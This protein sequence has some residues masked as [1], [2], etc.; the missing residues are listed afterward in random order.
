M[1]SDKRGEDRGNKKE[2]LLLL[3]R[4]RL[5][6]FEDKK[7]GSGRW[8]GVRT[9]VYGFIVQRGGEERGI[10]VQKNNIQYMCVYMCKHVLLANKL[11]VNFFFSS[12]NNL[13]Q[14]IF[15]SGR[16]GQLLST[17]NCFYWATILNQGARTHAA[18]LCHRTHRSKHP[19]NKLFFLL[20]IG[21]LIDRKLTKL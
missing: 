20:F 21:P 11:F 13:T 7:V 9:K 4:D 2:K 10:I 15:W 12:K 1:R 19:S 14:I 3:W 17:S 16:K 6:D 18:G 5:M 8:W